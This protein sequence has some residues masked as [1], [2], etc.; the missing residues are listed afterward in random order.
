MRNN[1]QGKCCGTR[2]SVLAPLVYKGSCRG[3]KGLKRRD[4]RR[5][6]PSVCESSRYRQELNNNDTCIT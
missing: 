6:T 2:G 1:A 5:D 3:D 4:G